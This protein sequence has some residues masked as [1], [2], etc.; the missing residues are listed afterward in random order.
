[1]RKHIV[2]FAAI[3]ISCVIGA[4]MSGSSAATGIVQSNKTHAMA[5]IT[6]SDVSSTASSSA[7]SSAVSSS[8]SSAPDVQAQDVSSST[9]STVDNT[10]ARNAAL[11]T[12]NDRHTQA[13]ADI[14]AQYDPQI[15]ALQN[16]ID[17]FTTENARDTTAEIAKLQNDYDIPF[18]QYND[19][20]KHRIECGI[21]EP[22]RQ[23]LLYYNI[24]MENGQTLTDQKPGLVQLNTDYATEQSDISSLPSVTAS[25]LNAISNESSYH[26]NN[27]TSIYSLYP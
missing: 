7:V 4:S 12:E 11:Q 2:T 20:N 23:E 18:K 14:D 27:L 26:L 13:L 16:E 6:S 10:D 24:M 5:D 19:Y 9:V 1:M 25:K 8:S 15:T 22:D 3:I 17:G 21:A